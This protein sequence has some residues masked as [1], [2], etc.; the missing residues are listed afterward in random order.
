MEFN[1]DY[2][3]SD[4]SNQGSHSHLFE[5]S[6]SKSFSVTDSNDVPEVLPDIVKQEKPEKK[7][8]EKLEKHIK[9]DKKPRKLNRLVITMILWCKLH[10]YFRL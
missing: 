4:N 2:D 6:L 3:F 1:S 7:K 9:S 5:E 8:Q 10:A